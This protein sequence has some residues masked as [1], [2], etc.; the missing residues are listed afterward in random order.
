[1]TS[2]SDKS[3]TLHLIAQRALKQIWSRLN[4]GYS[5]FDVKFHVE[6]YIKNAASRLN[7][8]SGEVELPGD[9]DFAAFVERAV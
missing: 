5:S 1:M 9:T 8:E 2:F 7:L 6:Y 3:A 4:I